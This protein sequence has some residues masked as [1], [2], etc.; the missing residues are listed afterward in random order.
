MN[1]N[2]TNPTKTTH[3][4]ED[5]KHMM[6]E[7]LAT[8]NIVDSYIQFMEPIIDEG[9]EMDKL[10]FTYIKAVRPISNFPLTENNNFREDDI[11]GKELEKIFFSLLADTSTVSNILE[12]ATS[13]TFDKTT[14]DFESLSEMKNS[15]SILDTLSALGLLGDTNFYVYLYNQPVVDFRHDMY[16]LF[17]SCGLVV[18]EWVDGNSQ[19]DSYDPNRA[20]NGE[21]VIYFSVPKH[22]QVGASGKELGS[23]FKKFMLIGT[24]DENGNKTKDG[25]INTENCPSYT[26]KFGEI[27]KMSFKMRIRDELWTKKDFEMTSM[28][29]DITNNKDLNDL[30]DY[31]DKE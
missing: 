23:I 7:E 15:L 19:S 22:S 27:N 18:E 26:E 8:M 28:L 12:T 1:S 4:A 25:G 30:L 2:L 14:S 11:V 20:E 3:T 17:T 29:N 31:M 24:F 10:I 5:Y 16:S 9:N 21:S 6:T 13:N